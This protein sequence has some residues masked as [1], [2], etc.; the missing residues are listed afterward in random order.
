ME[1]N[2]VK[3]K[4]SELKNITNNGKFNNNKKFKY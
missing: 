2:V 3:K 1:E 4:S